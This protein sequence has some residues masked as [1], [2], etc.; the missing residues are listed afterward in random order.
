MQVRAVDF[1]WDKGD[2]SATALSV[3]CGQP[4][5]EIACPVRRIDAGRCTFP[6]APV[7]GLRYSPCIR[8]Y[9]AAPA[10]RAPQV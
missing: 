5:G 8:G 1:S 7:T 2:R 3:T 10:P 4:L 6:A 9:G